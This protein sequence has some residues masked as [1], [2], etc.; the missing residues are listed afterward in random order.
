MS[1]SS[2]PAGPPDPLPS[3]SVTALQTRRQHKGLWPRIGCVFGYSPVAQ[4]STSRGIFRCAGSSGTCD[5]ATSIRTSARG[6]A[7]APLRC[8]WL[9]PRGQSRRVRESPADCGPSQPLGDNPGSP[10]WTVSCAR[11]PHTRESCRVGWNE[12]FLLTNRGSSTRSCS[13]VQPPSPYLVAQARWVRL[14]VAG[15]GAVSVTSRLE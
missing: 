5:L 7:P 1:T 12:G 15:F 4:H 14:R 3:R 9:S 2:M 6:S 11:A 8:K 13:P 10:L